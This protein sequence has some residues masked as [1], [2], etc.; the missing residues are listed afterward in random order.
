MRVRFWIAAVGLAS[1]TLSACGAVSSRADHSG[2]GTGA[3][4]S[5]GV[6]T[7]LTAST[8][9]G[10]TSLVAL[11]EIYAVSYDATLVGSGGP[12]IPNAAAVLDAG[13]TPCSNLSALTASEATLYG[14]LVSS[15]Q[16]VSED[17]ITGVHLVT[18]IP[19]YSWYCSGG[20]GK[21]YLWSGAWGPVPAGAESCSP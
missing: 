21:P 2:L 1:L 18:S 19:G 3:S 16:A 17:Q 6:G 13:V 12:V 14:A 8:A 20:S 9:N 7:A 5:T 15:D 10:C 4:L 11:E